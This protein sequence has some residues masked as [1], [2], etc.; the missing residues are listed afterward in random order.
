V[1]F[2]EE[3]VIHHPGETQLDPVTGNRMPG[4]PPEPRKVRG[5]WQQVNPATSQKEFG[6]DALVDDGLLLLAPSAV[7][8]EKCSVVGPDGTRWRC[9]TRPRTRRRVRGSRVSK[10]I[11]VI[12][13]Q[14][15]DMKG[16][17]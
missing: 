3:W 13:R 14:P 7:L 9:I 11:A 16:G 2:P 1:R 8:D 17:Q 10:Y 12:V 5:L 6:V 4:S 15:T